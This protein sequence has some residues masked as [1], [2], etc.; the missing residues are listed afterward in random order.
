M[1]KE[2]GFNFDDIELDPA[3]RE[4]AFSNDYEANDDDGLDGRIVITGGYNRQEGPYVEG[5][6]EIDF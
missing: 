6:I 5:S 1:K 3:E 4:E 2:K